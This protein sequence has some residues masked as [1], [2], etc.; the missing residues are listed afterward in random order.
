MKTH[1]RSPLVEADGHQQLSN[2]ASAVVDLPVERPAS[3]CGK[4][5]DE[6][7]RELAR[8]ESLRRELCRRLEQSPHEPTLP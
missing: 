1:R 8:F 3:D 5:L 7:V 2:D 6:M 4:L